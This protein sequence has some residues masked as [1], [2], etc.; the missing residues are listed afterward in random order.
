[1]T[2]TLT[3]FLALVALLIGLMGTWLVAENRDRQNLRQILRMLPIPFSL[4]TEPNFFGE[5]LKIAGAMTQI[6]KHTDSLFRELGRDRLAYMATELETL[7]RGEVAFNGTETW[8]TAY[9]HVLET[10]HVKTYYSVAWVRTGD[11]WDDAPGRQSMRFNYELVERG[12]RIERCHILPDELWPFDETMPRADI[13]EWLIEQEKHGIIISVIR[14]AELVNEPDLLRDF[15]IYGDRAVGVQELD[16]Q[17]RTVR[18]VLSF[19]QM[20]IRRALDCWERLALYSTPYRT[21][22]AEVQF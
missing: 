10:L 11:Y 5:Y 17:A 8:R 19:D 20:S 22:V 12:F 3:I 13:L 7:A 6:V 9:Q 18:F 15:A 16:G 2:S 4:A 14:E 21:L 1:M